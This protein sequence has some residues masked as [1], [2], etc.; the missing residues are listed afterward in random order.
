MSFVDSY[1]KKVEEREKSN[2]L[3]LM[4][5]I[6]DYVDETGMYCLYMVFELKGNEIYT[7]TK[8]DS[9]DPNHGI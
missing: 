6:L 7:P 1:F 4:E 5:S 2:K 8:Y 3:Q 9:Y